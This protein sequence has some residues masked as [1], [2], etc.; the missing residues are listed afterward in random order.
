MLWD[1]SSVHAESHFQISNILR[2]AVY[3]IRE[4]QEQ[5]KLLGK[6]T[7]R[8]EKEESPVARFWTAAEKDLASYAN[9]I[10]QR[11]EQKSEET[12]GLREGVW[13]PPLPIGCMRRLMRMD[14]FTAPMR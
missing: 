11:I 12:K 9:D 5:F 13:G 2:V 1:S 8:L 7:F 14:S 6:K 10:L 3:W 4:T